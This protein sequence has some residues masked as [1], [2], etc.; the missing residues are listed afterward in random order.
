MANKQGEFVFGLEYRASNLLVV[1]I[2]FQL[3]LSV[4]LRLLLANMSDS[5]RESG[6]YESD[7]V[8][9]SK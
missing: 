7:A 1:L 4:Y 8:T 6:G 2:V 9:A 5:Q 3:S